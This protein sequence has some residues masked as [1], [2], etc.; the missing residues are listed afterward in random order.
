MFGDGGRLAGAKAY[1]EASLVRTLLLLLQELVLRADRVGPPVRRQRVV[2]VLSQLSL[3]SR[4]LVLA[5]STISL[6]VGGGLRS[7]FGGAD[8]A[9]VQRAKC[10]YTFDVCM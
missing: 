3:T 7:G 10:A 6:D 1:N 2:P 4:D 9:A 8:E 5:S